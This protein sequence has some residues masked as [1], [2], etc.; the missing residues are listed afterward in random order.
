MHT[1]THTNTHTHTQDMR[2]AAVTQISKLGGKDRAETDR[3]RKTD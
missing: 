2:Q 3:E 1:H